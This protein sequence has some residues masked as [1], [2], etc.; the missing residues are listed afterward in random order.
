MIWDLVYLFVVFAG[1][2]IILC[3]IAAYG[4]DY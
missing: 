3:L 4:N 2:V 1:M